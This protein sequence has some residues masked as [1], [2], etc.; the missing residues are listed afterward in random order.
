MERLETAGIAVD[1][2][3]ELSAVVAALAHQSVVQMPRLRSAV[4]VQN[5]SGQRGV[6][7]TGKQIGANTDGEHQIESADQSMTRAV[8]AVGSGRFRAPGGLLQG[9]LRQNTS[10]RSVSTH[11]A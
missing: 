11:A 10:P 5:V 6:T 2:C 8:I 4:N 9:L 1:T 7:E 3:R